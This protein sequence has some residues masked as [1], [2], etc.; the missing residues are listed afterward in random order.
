M[1]VC[2]QWFLNAIIND[3]A[4]WGCRLAFCLPDA[5]TSTS[6]TALSPEAIIVARH[7][8]CAMKECHRL[9]SALELF[10]SDHSRREFFKKLSGISKVM[11]KYVEDD[12]WKRSFSH[13]ENPSSITPFRGNYLYR[14]EPSVFYPEN[15]MGNVPFWHS[16]NVGQ[17]VWNKWLENRCEYE[18]P[19]KENKIV[20]RLPHVS[21]RIAHRTK[22]M[23]ETVE[24]SYGKVSRHI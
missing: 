24:N 12:I 19:R 7:I 6:S 3:L 18:F 15:L 22:F 5:F 10:P 8:F 9:R 13:L 11:R 17:N 1:Q 2:D 14:D 4:L 23:Y 16:I 20:Q 21:L